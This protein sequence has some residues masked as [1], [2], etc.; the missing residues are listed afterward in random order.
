MATLSEF[1]PDLFKHIY[2]VDFLYFMFSSVENALLF[3]AWIF[4]IIPS[5]LYTAHIY[6]PKSF[7]GYISVVLFCFVCGFLVILSP[8]SLLSYLFYRRLYMLCKNR[9]ASKTSVQIKSAPTPPPSPSS[10]SPSVNPT[11]RSVL[12]T[13]GTMPS[14][15][16]CHFMWTRSIMFCDHVQKNPSLQCVTYLW[17][18]YFYSITKHIRD[19]NL[20]DEIYTQFKTSAEPFIKDCENKAM[21][22]HC[23]QSAY[24]QFRNILNSSGIDPRMQD[25]ISK[26]WDLT[27]QWAFPNA[28]LPEGAETSFSHNVQLLVNHTLTLYGL[29]PPAETVYYMESANGMTVRVPESKLEAWHAEQDRIRNDPAAAELTEAEKKLRDAILHDLYRKRHSS[30]KGSEDHD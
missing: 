20:I 3:L 4:I 14:Y 19:Q 2:S 23:I 17:T 16:V 25:G 22:L 27:A 10:S 13:Q 15:R 18:A 21:S 30:Y 11:V 6:K 7:L 12:P 5:M 28:P 9:K 1:L 8:I 24:W 29:K 26:L